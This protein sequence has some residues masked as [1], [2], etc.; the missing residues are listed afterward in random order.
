M[1][2]V[3]FGDGRKSSFGVVEWKEEGSWARIRKWA[4]V[5]GL[6]GRKRLAANA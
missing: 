2:R 4:A 1:C 6:T 3:K 5:L